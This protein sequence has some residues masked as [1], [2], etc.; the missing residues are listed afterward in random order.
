[1][2]VVLDQRMLYL[3]K[4][5]LPNWAPLIVHSSHSLFV[6]TFK[7]GTLTNVQMYH[8]FVPHS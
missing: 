6:A 1:M 5:R 2:H 3:P 7:N 4:A 8:P